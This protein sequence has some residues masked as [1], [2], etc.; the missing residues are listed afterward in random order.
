MES[1]HAE[2]FGPHGNPSG[3]LNLASVD[4][5]VRDLFDIYL[6]PFETVLAQTRVMAVMSSY[7]SWNR[8][9]NSASHF[10]LTEIL[11]K[12]IWFSRVCIF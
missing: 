7:N 4:C 12:Q 11:Q 6:K 3:G 8:V 9:P 1:P 10:M 5:G 2:T